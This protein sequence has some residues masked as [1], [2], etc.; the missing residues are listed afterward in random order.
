MVRRQDDEKVERQGRGIG[1]L[2][3]GR[4][5]DRER[6]RWKGSKVRRQEGRKVGRQKGRKVGRQKSWNVGRQKGKGGRCFEEACT[7]PQV[8]V[9]PQGRWEGEKIGSQKEGRQED[10][11]VRRQEG[12]R[13]EG[14]KMGRRKGRKLEMYQRR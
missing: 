14:M 5:E 2:Q 13:R 3:V 9:V 11:K 7:Q 8:E 6:D 12:R 1:R 4:Q 10:G